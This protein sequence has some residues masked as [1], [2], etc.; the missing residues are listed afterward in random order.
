MISETLKTIDLASMKSE[1]AGFAV[2][3]EKQ[4]LHAT[5]QAAVQILTK[6]DFN[7]LLNANNDARSSAIRRLTRFIERERLKGCTKHW[8]YDLNKHI[9][10][11]QALERLK[12][13]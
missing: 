4:I 10:L 11:K 2:K 9:A 13:I 8:S 12:S 5:Q 6:M 3:K 1:A 7:M